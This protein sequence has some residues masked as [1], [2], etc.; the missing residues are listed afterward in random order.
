VLPQKELNQKL[1]LVL[2]LA[3]G[4]I[5]TSKL[6]QNSYYAAYAEHGYNNQEELIPVVIPDFIFERGRSVLRTT[7]IK[8]IK[9]SN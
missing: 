8:L 3:T 2:P 9:E 1:P 6:V 7:E 5:T 4:I